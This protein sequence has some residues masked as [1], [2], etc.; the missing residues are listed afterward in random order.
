MGG[1]RGEGVEW[2]EGGEGGEGGVEARG[3]AHLAAQRRVAVGVHLAKPA[4]RRAVGRAEVV[5]HV[6]RERRAHRHEGG[7]HCSEEEGRGA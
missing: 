4:Q 6:H 2:G 1:E 3:G 5:E 7:H